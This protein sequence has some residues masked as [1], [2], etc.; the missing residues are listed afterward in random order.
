MNLKNMTSDE[1]IARRSAIAEEIEKPDANLEALKAEV[2][3]INAE[4]ESRKAAAAEREEIRKSIANGA[5]AVVKTEG[6]KPAYDGEYRNSKEYVDAYAEYVRNEGKLDKLSSEHRAALLTENADGTVA[7]PTFVEDIIKTAWEREGV[8]SKVNKTYVKGNLEIGF[9]ISG[10]DANI[11]TEGGDAVAEEDLV[12]GVVKLI[13]QSFKKWKSVS[14]E[15]VDLRGEAFLRYIMNELAYRIVKKQADYLVG[16]IAA[17]GTQS[18]TTAVGV[19]KITA[20][21]AKVGVVAKALG[22]LS[23]EAD[24]PAAI[25]NKKTWAIFKE[26]AYAGNFNADPFEG[27]EV[28]FNNSLTAFDAATTGVTYMIIGD[29]GN[30]AQANYPNG[31]GITTKIDDKTRMKQDLVD[32]LGR[33]FAGIDIVGPGCFVKVCK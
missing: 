13:P 11:H 1:L 24:K 33:Q 25:M 30:G 27:L 6:K 29:L 17:R 10:S 8:M 23:D 19:A 3:A 7:V 20:T 16:L 26:A 5:G 21:Q 9:E 18:T 12:L 2:R 4:L 14:D 28:V 15:V 32:I 22:E 31:E